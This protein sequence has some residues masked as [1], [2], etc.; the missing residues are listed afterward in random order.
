MFLLRVKVTVGAI[1]VL[2]AA[3]AVAQ[4]T[5]SVRALAE[6]IVERGFDNS[7]LGSSCAALGVAKLN[8]NCLYYQVADDGPDKFIH[9]FNVF[10]DP[11]TGGLHIIII[12]HN[13][14]VARGYLTD[15]DGVLRK[16]VTGKK[17]GGWDWFVIA[18]KPDMNDDLAKEFAFWRG[19]V[20]E[21]E[22]LKVPGRKK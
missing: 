22:D 20:K 5:I 21:I 6:L 11:A 3:S 4:E 17:T 8:P 9:S 10:K 7:R 19:K 12:R 14:K 15:G 16:A 1:L 13:N 18:T 2:V